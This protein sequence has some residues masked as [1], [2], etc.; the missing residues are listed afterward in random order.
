MTIEST[1]P[2]HDAHAEECVLG[3]ML[4]SKEAMYSG[5]GVLDSENFYSGANQEV[6][7]AIKSLA[8]RGKPVDIITVSAEVR[9]SGSIEH[10]ATYVSALTM[11]VAGYVKENFS[12]WV[13]SIKDQYARREAKRLSSKLSSIDASSDIEVI[14]GDVETHLGMIRSAMAPD[15]VRPLSEVI[16]SMVDRVEKPV[17]IKPGF[18]RV[19]EYLSFG[20]G[21]V[22]VVSARPG[23]G[24]TAYALNMA[25]NMAHSG[26]RVIYISLEM[27][28]TELGGRLAA[29]LS[30]V[31]SSKII[32]MEWSDE[33]RDVVA[34]SSFAT[35]VTDRVM[36]VD[37]A[38]LK[39]NSLF[40][41][42]D[43]AVKVHGCE[44][45]VIDYLQLAD[46]SEGGTEYEKTTIISK[47]VKQATKASGIRTIAVSQLSRPQKTGGKGSFH[48]DIDDDE[49]RRPRNSDLRGSGQ[50][51]QDAHSITHLYYPDAEDNSKLG[52][53]IGKNRGG[54]RKSILLHYDKRTQYIT[55]QGESYKQDNLPI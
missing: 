18:G 5:I 27:T 36:V 3:I 46:S 15:G 28:E 32:K 26:H 37:L 45:C 22:H 25:L 4:T 14:I 55:D 34:R 29:M 30:Q 21:E 48:D 24:K 6:F 1:I 50:L 35:D 53:V 51:E 31:D 19:S 47:R 7:K 9:A 52:A 13:A 44:V 2:P 42:L 39:I 41:I 8:H 17:Y 12:A 43:R 49:N 23:V 33:E 16:A 54:H 38:Y 11:K 20:P 40:G 10:P